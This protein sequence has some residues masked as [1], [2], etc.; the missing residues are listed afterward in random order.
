MKLNTNPASTPQHQ[1]DIE[2]VEGRRREAH[3]RRIESDIDQPAHRI[4]GQ[5]VQPFLAR[6]RQGRAPAL[7]RKVK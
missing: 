5:K 6:R 2:I 7:A 3:Q 4:G 1:R